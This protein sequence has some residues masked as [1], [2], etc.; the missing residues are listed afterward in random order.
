MARRVRSRIHNTP[1]SM[2][3]YVVIVRVRD[4]WRFQFGSCGLEVPPT[5]LV[6]G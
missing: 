3:T 2:A 1:P 5:F 4:R 6:I